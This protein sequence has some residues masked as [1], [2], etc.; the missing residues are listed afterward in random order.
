M[1]SLPPDPSLARSLALA[2]ALSLSI[3]LTPILHRVY[4]A[5]TALLYGGNLTMW[6]IP[7]ATVSAGVTYS[8]AFEVTNPPHAN[9]A[10]SVS[11]AALGPIAIARVK[12]AVAPAAAGDTHELAPLLV[13]R[14]AAPRIFPA[15]AR[16]CVETCVVSMRS[17]TQGATIFYSTNATAPS[18]MSAVYSEQVQ[19]RQ[20]AVVSAIA[21]K[22]GLLPSSITQSGLQQIRAAAPIFTPADRQTCPAQRC[23]VSVIAPTRDT[24]VYYRVFDAAAEAAAGCNLTASWMVYSGP[25]DTGSSGSIVA[26]A[27]KSEGWGIFDSFEVH[28]PAP[29]RLTAR[30]QSALHRV[31]TQVCATT[32]FLSPWTGLP[33]SI[34]TAGVSSSFFLVARDNQSRVV[35]EIYEGM[36]PWRVTAY[37][38]PS[39]HL[40]PLTNDRYYEPAVATFSGTVSRHSTP[41]S[42]P[43]PQEAGGNTAV[44]A[45]VTTAYFLVHLTPVIAE[46]HRVHVQL[47]NADVD[48]SPFLLTVR[49]AATVCGSKSS[50][51]G[52]GLTL[53]SLLPARNVFTIHARDEYGNRRPGLLPTNHLF[54]SRLVR[55]HPDKGTPPSLSGAGSCGAAA[56]STCAG[57]LPP[58]S[59]LSAGGR[60][61]PGVID[62]QPTIHATVTTQEDHLPAGIC[63]LPLTEG[64]GDEG[65][66]GLIWSKNNVR[67]VA[68]NLDAA[69][70]PTYYYLDRE[71][72]P[73][74]N[75]HFLHTHFLAPGGLHATY[76]SS[77]QPITS[78]LPA[79][80]NLTDNSKKVTS[81]LGLGAPSPSTSARNSPVT[82]SQSIDAGLLPDAHF[83]VRWSGMLGLEA[84]GSAL[85]RKFKWTGM[86]SAD[87]VRLWIDNHLLMDEWTSLSD[88][89]PDRV[90]KFPEIDRKY[91][92]HLEWKRSNATNHSSSPELVECHAASFW[93]H[94]PAC[95]LIYDCSSRVCSGGNYT[96]SGTCAGV[97]V[98][99]HV[100]LPACDNRTGS[101]S[102]SSPSSSSC[103]CSFPNT[104]EP[105]SGDEGCVGG[106]KCAIGYHSIPSSRLFLAY[107]VAGSPVQVEVE[108]LSHCC[109]SGPEHGS[110]DHACD[111]LV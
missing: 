59:G 109:E 89:A 94:C 81:F 70:H 41:E 4:E 31:L 33:L 9:P 14:V 104:G 6:L 24:V 17:A 49:P 1:L 60:S 48:G 7:E 72:G 50:L 82:N 56:T 61:P 64:G 97:C 55:M 46:V 8:L 79:P 51:A 20:H 37:R 16:T 105:C 69:E 84:Y 13:D 44:T 98:C 23:N 86:H 11:V 38:Q 42:I 83:V 39:P 43:A 40:Y 25:I 26:Y 63:S 108:T 68:R 99:D 107:S 76:Y 29:Q 35:H 36:V 101:H 5:G 73:C 106:G 19:V 62:P 103:A 10:A 15:E 45:A 12:F 65:S 34:A 92:I 100:G 74:G 90:F 102:S 88:P 22:T 78:A 96:A 30:S 57:A 58:F 77:A 53:A 75:R 67:E 52:S 21:Y 87:R 91:D 66:G 3:D 71:I 111:P 80:A 32:S 95:E 27:R 18:N 28:W 54:Y 2:R 85:P 93:A 110:R 47:G